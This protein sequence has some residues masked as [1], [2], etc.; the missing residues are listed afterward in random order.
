MYHITLLIA[1]LT[2]PCSCFV[3][4]RRILSP[5]ASR[6]IGGELLP[7]QRGA[8]S[9]TMNASVCSTLLNCW[10]CLERSCVWCMTTNA[11]TALADCGF[12]PI[13]QDCCLTYEKKCDTCLKDSHCGFCHD[14]SGVQ[15][16]SGSL[17]GPSNGTCTNWFKSGCQG[18]DSPESFQTSFLIGLAI[19]IGCSFVILAIILL[20]IF[21]KRR[22]EQGTARK[23]LKQYLR[24]GA[25]DTGY[26]ESNSKRYLSYNGPINP[27]LRASSSSPGGSGAYSSANV[28]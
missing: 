14:T 23:A 6:N 19:A 18:I 11:C 22:I 21:I 9:N 28:P 1:H 26:E 27:A 10:S 25:T 20:S 17:T 4:N 5:R 12:A 15:C 13:K 7:Y 2:P 3:C 16:Q 24:Y 8:V